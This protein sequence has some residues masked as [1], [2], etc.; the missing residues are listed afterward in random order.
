MKIER[1]REREKYKKKKKK[2]INTQIER[3]I[4]SPIIRRLIND[5]DFKRIRK[6]PVQVSVEMERSKKKKK[7]RERNNCDM[8]DK[9]KDPKWKQLACVRCTMDELRKLREKS[10]KGF[11]SSGKEEEEG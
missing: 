11:Q 8:K 7:E 3:I 4:T 9:S 6:R 1:E 5:G 2:K 10:S